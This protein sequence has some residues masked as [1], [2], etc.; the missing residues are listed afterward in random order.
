LLRR[1]KASNTPTGKLRAMPTTAS[2]IVSI[3]PPTSWSRPPNCPER[4]LYAAQQQQRKG[5]RPA[6]NP[7]CHQPAA[8]RPPERTQPVTA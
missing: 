4:E 1:P 8:G 7:A 5:Q 2:S 3:K 6:E